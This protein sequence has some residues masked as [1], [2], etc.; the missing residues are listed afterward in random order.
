MQTR[1]RACNETCKQHYKAEQFL[2]RQ[3][4]SAYYG[5]STTLPDGE[6]M[7]LSTLEKCTQRWSCGISK[8]TWDFPTSLHNL[9]VREEDDRLIVNARNVRRTTVDLGRY[10]S[11]KNCA[12][13]ENYALQRTQC[14]A[15][16]ATV[17]GT[18]KGARKSQHYEKGALIA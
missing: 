11:D 6:A 14:T 2:D 12:V 16:I 3:R 15:K 17:R 10:C 5:S 1:I 13:Y 7:P 9:C 4:N 8:H 18:T